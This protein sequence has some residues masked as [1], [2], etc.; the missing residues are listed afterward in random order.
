[1]WCHEDLLL[2]Q[3]VPVRLSRRGPGWGLPRVHDPS[4]VRILSRSVGDGA[5]MIGFSMLATLPWSFGVMAGYT[6]HESAQG[7]PMADQDGGLW[8]VPAFAACALVNALLI[9]LIFRG[10]RIRG[11][12]PDLA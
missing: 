3:G 7:V 12:Q 4:A 8:M 2:T 6:A 5:F 1:M 10:R 11:S 9:W